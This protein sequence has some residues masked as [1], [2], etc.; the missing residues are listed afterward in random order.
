MKARLLT[1]ILNNTKYTVNNN[2]DYIAIGSPLCHDLISVNKKSLKIRYALDTWNEGRLSVKHANEELLFIWDKLQ[3]LIDNGQIKDIIDGVDIIENPLPVYT[4]KKGE[5]IESF[6]DKYGWPNTTINGEI[7]YNNVWF[8]TK[9]EAIKYG[10]E[11][12]TAGLSILGRRKQECE[13]DLDN[14]RT[15]IAEEWSH[16]E[17]IKRLLE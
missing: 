5:L 11:E 3:E 6:T 9:Q 14:I 1:K 8:K 17:N 15:Q 2:Q 12:Y 10:I 16:L 7:M 4:V 13:S